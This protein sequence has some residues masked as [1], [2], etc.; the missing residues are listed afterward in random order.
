MTDE[1]MTFERMIDEFPKEPI[2]RYEI[3]R[4]SPSVLSDD[5]R[6]QRHRLVYY[7]D[8]SWEQFCEEKGYRHR[9]GVDVVDDWMSFTDYGSGR[10]EV[11]GRRV[12]WEGGLSALQYFIKDLHSYATSEEVIEVLR[13][14]AEN[15]LER[16]EREMAEA[17]KFLEENPE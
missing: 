6:V 7:V 17:K 2:D 1:K 10:E 12:T 9:R 11:Q 15:T 13:T 8:M 16:A 5:Y 14:R 4:Y 3:V